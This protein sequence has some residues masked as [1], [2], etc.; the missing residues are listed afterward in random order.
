[1][2]LPLVATKNAGKIVRTH[3]TCGD[4]DDEFTAGFLEAMDFLQ[5]V[6]CFFSLGVAHELWPPE[7]TYDHEKAYEIAADGTKILVYNHFWD[8]YKHGGYANGPYV[9]Y[10][11]LDDHNKAVLYRW[12]KRSVR[13]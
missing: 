1:M 6:L 3:M 10:N 13:S 11:A 9:F 7:S 8:K 5:Y 12:Y 4:S 2:E